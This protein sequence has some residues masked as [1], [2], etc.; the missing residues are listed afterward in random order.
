MSKTRAYG[1]ARHRFGQRVALLAL[2]GIPACGQSK[3]PTR[4]PQVVSLI[5]RAQVELERGNFMTGLILADSASTLEPNSAEPHFVRGRLLQE[6]NQYGPADSAY[7]RVASIDQGFPGLG[8]NRGNVAFA[9]QQYRR[10]LG[11]YL[12]AKPVDARVYHALGGTYEQLGA[13]DSARTAYQAAVAADPDYAPVRYS[14]SVLLERSGDYE[15][16][17]SAAEEAARLQPALRSRLQLGRMYLQTGQYAE[18]EAALR[19]I[20]WAE[21]WN[22]TARFALGQTLQRAGRNKEAGEALMAADSVR[23]RLA[24]SEKL[25][26]AARD[27]PSAMAF[28]RYAEALRRLGRVDAALVAYN[29]AAA[30]APEDVALRTN[31][32]TLYLEIGRP[33]EGVSRLL[34]LG[35]DHPESLEPWINLALHYGRTR[36]LERTRLY[37]AKAREVAPAHPLV[38]RLEAALQGS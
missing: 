11:F 20:V 31:L 14:L 26:L 8:L 37:L 32:A 24:E 3:A 29:R 28:A 10:A 6:V 5:G 34:R 19:P 7:Q 36:D 33:E 9:Q 25:E 21:P 15:G 1:G 17:L 2:V 16:A 30:L 23:A 12:K 4:S 27:A 38:A 13:V 35:A 22:Y 18:A